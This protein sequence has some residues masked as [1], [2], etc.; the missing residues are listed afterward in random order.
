MPELLSPVFTFPRVTWQFSDTL[1][2]SL[3][4]RHLSKWFLKITLKIKIKITSIVRLAHPTQLRTQSIFHLLPPTH[5]YC[6][7]SLGPTSPTCYFGH[8]SVAAKTYRFLHVCCHGDFPNTT[9]SGH[10][11]AWIHQWLFMPC[12]VKTKILGLLKDAEAIWTPVPQSGHLRGQLCAPE[13]PPRA[14]ACF[15]LCH[16]PVGS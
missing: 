15:L 1:L 7:R 10:F 14:K 6:T 8:L 16:E 13:L 3:L 12:W 11:S 4:F 5:S 9:A 2:P